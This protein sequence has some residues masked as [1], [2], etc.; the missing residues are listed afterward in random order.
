R[1]GISAQK[2]GDT[3]AVFVNSGAG[4]CVNYDTGITVGSVS[5]DTGIGVDAGAIGPCAATAGFRCGAAPIRPSLFRGV[6]QGTCRAGEGFEGL[7]NRHISPER[8]HI[9]ALDLVRFTLGPQGHLA[10]EVF[11]LAVLP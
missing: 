2:N 6:G 8:V 10:I 4:T 3:M 7:P 1:N 11:Q 5:D 9:A